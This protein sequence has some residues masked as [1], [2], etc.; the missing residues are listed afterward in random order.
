MSSDDTV[1][2]V[3]YP[4][5]D[6]EKFRAFH[7]QNAEDMYYYYSPAHYFTDKLNAC[8]A[9]YTEFGTYE[10]A[11]T[12]IKEYLTTGCWGIE[13]V[14]YGVH[15]CSLL[16]CI[17]VPEVLDKSGRPFTNYENEECPPWE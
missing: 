16:E 7:V 4:T 12:Y 11:F 14:E 9:F 5:K 8:Y 3:S 6:G 13:Y 10:E 15:R 17:P 2:I 1:F